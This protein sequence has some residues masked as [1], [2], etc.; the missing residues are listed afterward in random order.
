MMPELEKWE[1][2]N[3]TTWYNKIFKRRIMMKNT[4][5]QWVL[6]FICLLLLYLPVDFNWAKG[7]AANSPGKSVL[8]NKY[9]VKKFISFQELKNNKEIQS[10]RLG[11]IYL[12]NININH[13]FKLLIDGEYLN[14]QAIDLSNKRIKISTSYEIQKRETKELK[15]ADKFI[16][17]ETILANNSVIYYLEDE[18]LQEGDKIKIEVSFEEK[19][20]EDWD[21]LGSDVIKLRIKR[22]GIKIYTRETLAF[23]RD[24]FKKS[25]S[26][27][28]GTSFTFG[29]TFY[30]TKK[31]PGFFKWWKKLFNGIEPRIG[32]NLTLLDFDEDEN[33]EFGLGPVFSIFKGTFYL[34]VGWNLSTTRS[35][36]RYAYFGISVT[37]IANLIKGVISK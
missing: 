10:Y 2:K 16:V 33:L 28:P 6:I 20:N 22:C 37:E 32:V 29:Y 18:G 25:W 11:E 3:K 9:D 21:T 5:F 35:K 17:G 26:P 36:D 14:N 30:I 15:S 19:N 27:Q 7:E 34:G 12:V 4:R 31:T 23:V 13:Q 8:Q 24:S 1:L